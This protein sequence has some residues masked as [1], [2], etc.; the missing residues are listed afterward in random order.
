MRAHPRRRAPWWSV[1]KAQ[2]SPPTTACVRTLEMGFKMAINARV[3]SYTVSYAAK[4]FRPRI[5]LKSGVT[6]FEPG[7]EAAQG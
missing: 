4:P 5:G 3:D 6:E 7:G 1:A 2:A